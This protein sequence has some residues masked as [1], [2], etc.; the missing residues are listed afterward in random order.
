MDDPGAGGA[1]VRESLQL[2]KL[3]ALKTGGG[4]RPEEKKRKQ[5]RDGKADAKAFGKEV[6]E[7]VDTYVRDGLKPTGPHCDA[8]LAKA[9][10]IAQQDKTASTF[11]PTIGST[12]LEVYVTVQLKAKT[13]KRLLAKF[14]VL[15]EVCQRKGFRPSGNLDLHHDNKPHFRGEVEIIVSPEHMQ[16][17]GESGSKLNGSHDDTGGQNGSAEMHTK[18][19]SLAPLG[20][21]PEKKKSDNPKVQKKLLQDG[22]IFKGEMRDG[23]P[24]GFGAVEYSDNDPKQRVRFAGEFEDGA[25]KGLGCLVWKDGA[26]YAGDWYADKPSGFGVENYPDGSSYGGQ[27][28]DDMR[29]GY[30]TYSFPSGAKYEGCWFMGKRHGK[31]LEASKKGVFC[32]EFDNNKRIAQLEFVPG[33]DEQFD[34]LISKVRAAVDKGR[35]SGERSIVAFEQR[36]ETKLRR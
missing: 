22:S 19:P 28:E 14:S 12:P 24:H 31:A 13:L 32:V 35:K 6:T 7:E 23:K 15:A 21:E 4:D 36:F 20:G 17:R 1:D 29:H 8:L 10:E 33:Q 26:Q 30:G 16:K 34:M 27:Y 11:K 2:E 9:D 3:K 18:L 25:R 5:P